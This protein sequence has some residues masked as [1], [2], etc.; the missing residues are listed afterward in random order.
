MLVYLKP[1][2]RPR[3]S[4]DETFCGPLPRD[5]VTPQAHDPLA[6]WAPPREGQ[7]SPGDRGV[8]GHESSINANCLE[9]RH[10]LPMMS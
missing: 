10:R 6:V 8:C 4:S 7:R 2:L 9:A 5:P 1:T 3:I